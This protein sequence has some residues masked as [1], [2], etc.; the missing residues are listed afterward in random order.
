M[1]VDRGVVKV[2][3]YDE[4][5]EHDMPSKGTPFSGFEMV[6][7]ITSDIL[8]LQGKEHAESRLQRD[9]VALIEK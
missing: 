8:A 5:D 1:K 3:R 4:E 2:L 7:A 9:V 6:W